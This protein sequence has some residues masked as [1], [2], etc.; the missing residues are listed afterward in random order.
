MSQINLKLIINDISVG[1]PIQPSHGFALLIN[2]EILFDTG[3][4]PE[5]LLSNMRNMRIDIQ[6]INTIFLSHPHLDHTGGLEGILA[7]RQ[8]I[9]VYA[10]PGFDEDV[11]GSVK[12][13]NGIFVENKDFTKIG[14]GLY[15]TGEM[16]GEYKAKYMPEQSL[17]LSG[18]NGIVIVTGCAHAG[19]VNIVERAKC[20]I[21]GSIRFVIGGFHLRSM[22]EEDIRPIVDKTQ[23]LGCEKVAPVH[24]TGEKAQKIFQEVYGDNFINIKAGQTIEL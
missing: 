24:C 20:V 16:E 9:K 17:L 8:G 11:K 18:D 7:S 5:T 13:F 10:C 19:I 23:A 22:K 2:D 15:T 1:A 14:E 12:K 21:A 4:D 3:S 6:K